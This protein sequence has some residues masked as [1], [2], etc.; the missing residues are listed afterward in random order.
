[1]F[2][3]INFVIYSVGQDNKNKIKNK[4]KSSTMNRTA[5]NSCEQKRLQKREVVD[6]NAGSSLSD[7]G[8][9]GKP[10]FITSS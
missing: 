1:M 5:V 8:R 6:K 9:V 3:S 7:R 10:G 4:S 2:Y